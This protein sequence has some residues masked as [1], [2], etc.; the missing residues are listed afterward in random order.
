MRNDLAGK[1]F[2]EL[3]AIKVSLYKGPRPRIY[4]DCICS[5]G[6]T[7]SIASDSLIGGNTKSCGHLR[8]RYKDISGVRFGRLVA[9]ERLK[10]ED[11]NGCRIKC[12]CDCGNTITVL[13]RSLVSGNT[14]SCGCLH[15]DSMR[16]NNSGELNGR[17]NPDLTDEER[18]IGRNYPEYNEWRTA[19]YEKDNYTC[20]KCGGSSGVALNAHHIESYTINKDLRTSLENGITL[21]ADKCHPNFHH[22]Y[23]YG[24][25]TREQFNEWM[26]EE[27][28]DGCR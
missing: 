21:C 23:G 18:K 22:I 28:N 20:Q 11:W 19:V 6:E 3:T 4:W 10:A 16:E 1:T 2:G 15:A 7:V 8:R 25:N 13:R 5:C 12:I 26:G 17:W 9:G 14:R 24:H 27:V